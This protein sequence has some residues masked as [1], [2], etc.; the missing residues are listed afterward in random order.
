MIPEILLKFYVLQK[1]LQNFTRKVMF[2]IDKI[3]IFLA[4]IY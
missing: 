1:I 4:G 2:I 3:N